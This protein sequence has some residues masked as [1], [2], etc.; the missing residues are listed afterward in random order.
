MKLFRIHSFSFTHDA[1]DKPGRLSYACYSQRTFVHCTALTGQGCHISTNV[2]I[3]HYIEAEWT[4]LIY[5]MLTM[6]QQ[7]SVYTVQNTGCL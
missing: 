4:I 3:Y 1:N 7:L 6:L 5:I 2:Y